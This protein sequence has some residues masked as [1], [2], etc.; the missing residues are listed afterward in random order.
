MFH[1]A[2]MAMPHPSEPL[3]EQC[4]ELAISKRASLADDSQT[5]A[6]R[7]VDGEADGFPGVVVEIFDG[8]WLV[9]TLGKQLPALFCESH[10][11]VRALYWKRLDQDQKDVP[12]WIWGERVDAPFHVLEDGMKIELSM[13]SGYSQGLFLDQRLNRR[14]VRD[15]M[16]SGQR[17]LNTFSYTG[18]FSVAAALVGGIT[19]SLDLS[20]PY[21]QWGRRNLEANGIDPQSQYFC[22]GDA[23]SWMKRF[24]KQERLFTGII[25]DPPTFSRS[26]AGVFSVQKDYDKLVHAAAIITEP[27]GWILATCNDRRLEHER[28][29]VMV[30]EGVRF[31]GRQIV[32]LTHTPMPEDF[33]DEH[34]LKSIWVDLA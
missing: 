15:R 6:Y 30:R 14:R 21:L 26:D 25:L 19:T 4:L 32:E 5:T 17:V 12:Q 2:T 29:E 7:L 27:A 22:K 16:Q 31:A 3:Q 8:V 20:N 24:T 1:M 10:V 28:F 34:Y 11:D 13:Q 9:S 18:M 23:M 33:I